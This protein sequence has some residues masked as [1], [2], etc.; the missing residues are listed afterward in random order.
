METSLKMPHHVADELTTAFASKY[1][2][3]IYLEEALQIDIVAG[4]SKQATGEKYIIT[5]FK[6]N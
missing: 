2:Q 5:P 3:E 6:N 4:Y 1:T